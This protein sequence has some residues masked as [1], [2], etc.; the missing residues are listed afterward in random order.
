MV[1][2]KDNCLINMTYYKSIVLR[3]KN[4]EKHSPN[5][6]I[7]AET[8]D[9]EKYLKRAFNTQACE[10]LNGWLGGFDSILK[11]M[12]VD[13]FN[14]FLH[15]MLFYHTRYVLEKIK[16]RE[17]KMKKGDNGDGDDSDDDAGSDDN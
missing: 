10:Q 17:E 3:R 15:A 4:W 2:L 12:T 13:N 1:K 11:R 5:L 14:W 9:G 8:K 6:V 16:K 7:E